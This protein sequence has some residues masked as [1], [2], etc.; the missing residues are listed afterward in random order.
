MT[1][2]T[3]TNK[4]LLEQ[5]RR[6]IREVTTFG[7]SSSFQG[8]SKTRADLNALIASEKYYTQLVRNEP[9]D[10]PNATQGRNR[11]IYVVP[12]G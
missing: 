2:C 8:Q 4:E 7:Q 3:P 12:V 9:S 6:A 1:D 11:I 5:C 10:D